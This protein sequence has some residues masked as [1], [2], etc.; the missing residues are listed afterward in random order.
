[1]EDVGSIQTLL[2]GEKGEIQPLNSDEDPPQSAQEI[3]DMMKFIGTKITEVSRIPI[4]KHSTS[5]EW[6]VRP[7]LILI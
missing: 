1:M 5:L 6:R 2:N 4:L 7:V 3:L